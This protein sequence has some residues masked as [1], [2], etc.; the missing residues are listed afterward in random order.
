MAYIKRSVIQIANSTQLI[1]L[2]RKWSQKYGV[3]KGDELEI[4][5]NGSK[6]IISTEGAFSSQS[7]EINP[8]H[9]KNI[10]ERYI[11]TSFRAGIDDVQINFN[12]EENPE[13][14]EYV[15][16]TLDGQTIGFEIL[17]QEKNFFTI[18]DL[19]GTSSTSFENSLRRAFI[20]LTSMVAESLEFIK[21]KDVHNLNDMYFRDRSI[22]KFTNFCSRLLLKNGQFDT[23]NTAFY[24]HFIRSFEAL[25]DQYSLMCTYYAKKLTPV[26]KEV[27]E[28]YKEINSILLRFYEIFYKFDKKELNNLFL[29]IREME[30]TTREL[31]SLKKTDPMISYYLASIIRRIKELVDSL[32]EFNLDKG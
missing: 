17:R 8:P 30:N 10:T 2:P 27:F 23:K 6:L 20:L 1:S 12:V 22:N 15:S 9:L 13:L 5:E 3:K 25:A 7:I 26:N 19:A 31:Y 32:I 21:N 29:R 11:T 4:E 28:K 24:Y 14:L 16:K 18:K